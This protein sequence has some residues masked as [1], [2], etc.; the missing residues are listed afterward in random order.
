MKIR[1]TKQYVSE[2]LGK[3]EISINPL[4]HKN[5]LLEN[6]IGSDKSIIPHVEGIANF[7]DDATQQLIFELLQN[8][9]DAN[10]DNEGKGLFQIY[11]DEHYFLAINNGRPFTT[12]KKKEKD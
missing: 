5:E 11:Y 7:A 9:E 12:D 8:A 1:N 2:I 4:D 10:S 3:N 6:L